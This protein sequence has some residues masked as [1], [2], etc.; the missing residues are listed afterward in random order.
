MKRPGW[1]PIKRNRN[2][3]TVAQGLSKN[4]KL[5]IRKKWAELTV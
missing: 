3:G 5:V 4:N 1:N 2:I